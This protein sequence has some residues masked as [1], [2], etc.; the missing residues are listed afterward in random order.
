MT[1]LFQKNENLSDCGTV[2]YFYLN[3]KIVLKYVS[4]FFVFEIANLYN[5][6]CTKSGTWFAL[7]T[8]SEVSE[9]FYNVRSG[10]GEDKSKCV[11]CTLSY[12]ILYEEFQSTILSITI[13]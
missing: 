10:C 9:S 5:S 7:R 13:E 8:Q 3:G 1:P 12:V 6:G 4:T 11:M 2:V